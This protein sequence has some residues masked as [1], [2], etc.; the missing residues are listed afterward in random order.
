MRSRGVEP[1]TRLLGD[2]PEFMP[3]SR[4]T[5]PVVDRVKRVERPLEYLVRLAQAIFAPKRQPNP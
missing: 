3:G 4:N 2:S 5:T 1:L